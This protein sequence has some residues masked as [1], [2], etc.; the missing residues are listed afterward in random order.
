[1]S[2]I[3]PEADWPYQGHKSLV[4]DRVGRQGG[5]AGGITRGGWG[6]AGVGA[7][8]LGLVLLA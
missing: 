4:L 3:I 2:M 8:G 1:M 5:A 7:G 6:V